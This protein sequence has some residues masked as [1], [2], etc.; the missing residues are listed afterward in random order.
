MHYY[1]RTLSIP[2]F[3]SMQER[4]VYRVVKALAQ[5]LGSED[6]RG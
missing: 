1:E 5:A 3:P 6:L 2:L 4:D